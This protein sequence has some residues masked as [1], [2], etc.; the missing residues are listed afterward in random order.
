LNI[1]EAR[2]QD[3]A[4]LCALEARTP[5]NIGDASIFITHDSFFETHDLQERT[6]VMVAEEDGEIVGVTAGALNRVPLAG[7]ERQL[8][9]MH[10]SRIDP[11]HQRTGIGGALTTAISEHW[12][13]HD[14]GQIDSSYW[15]IGK[16]NAQSRAFAERGGNR[17][18]PGSAYLCAFE[19]ATA[20]GPEPKRIGAG[21]TFDIVR[22]INRTHQGE[23]LFRAYEHVDFGQRLARSRDYGWGDIYGRFEGERLVAVAGLWKNT[24]ADFGYE[25]GAESEV[26][27][28]LGALA[29]QRGAA[30]QIL[31]D[32]RSPLFEA[33]GIDRASQF[34]LLFYAPRVEPPADRPLLHI[35]PVYF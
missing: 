7:A 13:N 21:P 20:P 34:E 18:W 22:L 15:Y 32:G 12:K 17:P 9:Y 19:S 28:L 3:N 33:L 1:R 8:L 5:L 2:R 35:D 14:A 27:G 26:A 29:A 25:A 24:V 31:L 16:G 4:A 6:V 10:H 30:L 11:A 23:D